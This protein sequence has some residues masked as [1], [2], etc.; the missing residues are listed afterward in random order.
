MK[1]KTPLLSAMLLIGILLFGS[2]SANA[3][4]ASMKSFLKPA[5]K[6]GGFKMDGYFLWCPSVIKVGDT[7][8]MFCSRWPAS[9]GM[10]GWTKYSECVRATS[11]NLYG[12]YKFEEVVLQKR[13]GEWDN[14]R[15]HNVKIMKIGS[16][17]VIY[18][19]SSKMNTGYAYADKITG[20]WTRIDKPAV[21]VTNPAVV[22][23]PDN[24]IYVIGRGET[25][26]KL[27][28]ATA[29]TAPAFNGAYSIL[30]G[31]TNVLPNNY[32]L[33]DP[34]IWW[35]NNQ[36]NMLC[37]DW[38]GKATGLFKGGAQYYSKDGIN[39]VLVSKEPVFTKTI[40]FDDKTTE[41]FSRRERPFVYINEKNE[42][43]ALLTTCL[44]KD[45]P[46]RII[47]QPIDNYYPKN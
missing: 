31:G 44:P 46:A 23:K 39:Y 24:T 18:Y 1:I 34:T 9:V 7:Y 41:T 13:E 37:N 21:H 2:G 33:E 11:K 4:D 25:P 20:P 29:F 8:H 42:A 28:I 3:Q 22:V 45:G 43:T 6:E 17:Y 35:A 30:K 38:N 32:E 27:D 12:P 16:K 26:D 15:I 47:I 14:A 10:N 36:Y 40:E 19:I 5:V